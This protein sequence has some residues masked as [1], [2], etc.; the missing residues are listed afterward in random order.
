[1]ARNDSFYQIGTPIPFQLA[2]VN[3]GNAMDIKTG[4]FRA[5]RTGTYF[6]SFNGMVE[7]PAYPSRIG[8]GVSLYLNG[9]GSGRSWI[10]DF[11]T[12]FS[13]NDKVALQVTLNLKAGDQVWVEIDDKIAE[14]YLYD[15]YGGV[16]SYTHF[17]GWV[18]EEEIKNAP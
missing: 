16:Y 6:F 8:L 11:N 1:M 5:P 18:L 17:T 10:E 14:P 7:F 12:A 3:I 9:I 13:E 2:P 15:A 4:K